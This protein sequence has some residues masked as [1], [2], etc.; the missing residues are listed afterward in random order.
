MPQLFDALD[1]L[2]HSTF[3]G[4]W[5][6]AALACLVAMTLLWLVSLAKRDVSIVDVFWG[7]AFLLV[8]LVY[9]GAVP[10][11]VVGEGQS[12]RL[13][14]LALVALWALR[15]GG[16]I[17]WRSR[18]EGED[19]RYGA[20]RHKVGE[21]FRWRSLYR[22]FW[23]QGALVSVIAIPLFLVQTRPAPDLWRWSDGVGLALWAIGFVFE[24]GADYQLLRFKGD[25]ANRGQVLR[26]GFWALSRHPNYFGEACLWWGFFFFALAVP[27]GL[28]SLPSVLLMTFL[29]LRVSGVTLL[30]KTITERRPAYR[31]YIESTPSFL[32]RLPFLGGGGR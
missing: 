21:S 22:V 1:A 7:P 24:T 23:L 17:A 12:R 30:E 4:P 3:L 14:V 32:P 8:S 10:A 19:H 15:L 31:D 13:L 27:G 9:F 26:H 6:L 11:Q 5:S 29:L 2:A 28:W 20:M 18:G 16:H 25:P